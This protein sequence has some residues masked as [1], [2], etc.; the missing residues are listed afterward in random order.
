MQ[1]NLKSREVIKIQRLLEK[2]QN[3]NLNNSTR[4]KDKLTFSK[5]QSI[6]RNQMSLK[7]I[8]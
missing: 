1:R 4:T 3:K 5:I 2:K 7:K 6:R 8:N